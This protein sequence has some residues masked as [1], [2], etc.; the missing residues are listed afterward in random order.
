MSDLYHQSAIER[1]QS[2]RAAF[3]V[4]GSS[5]HR[6]CQENG[7]AMQNARAARLGSWTGPKAAKIDENIQVA[8]GTCR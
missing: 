6:W 2:I 3:V 4:K 1:Y 8:S 7:I 5:L